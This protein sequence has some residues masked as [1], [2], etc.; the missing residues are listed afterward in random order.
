MYLFGFHVLGLGSDSQTGK[1]RTPALKKLFIF[2]LAPFCILS[3]LGSILTGSFFTG[4]FRN[5]A[6]HELIEK[7]NDF[8]KKS[9]STIRVASAVEVFSA[10]SR[11]ARAVLLNRNADD[12]AIVASLTALKNRLGAENA[13]ILDTKGYVVIA[14][15]DSNSNLES[16]IGKNYGSMLYYRE[17]M[18]GRSIIYPE[19]GPS[20]RGIYV[21][22]PIRERITGLTDSRIIGVATVKINPGYL[23]E[24]LAATF[25][26]PIA[27]VSPKGR[28]LASNLPEWL[29]KTSYRTEGFGENVGMQDYIEYRLDQPIVNYK[30]KRHDVIKTNHSNFIDIDGQW[31]VCLLE[32][33]PRLD[34]IKL[35][36]GVAGSIFLSL[37]LL[38][39]FM[40]W[41]EANQ[42]R[43]W[44]EKQI[45][46]A[47]ERAEEASRSKSDFLASMSHEIRTP[48]N[49]I[50][51]MSELALR[52]D[53]PPRVG[54]HVIAIKQA[55]NNLLAIINDI[56]D[57][58]KIESGK[59]DI[60][61]CEYEVSSLFSDVC[62]IIKT[63]MDETLLL[64]TFIDS[65]LPS[66]LYGD[67]TRIRQVILNIL[68][69][70]VKYTKKGHVS[71][72]IIGTKKDG[73]IELNI[74]VSDTGIGIKKEDMEKLFGKFTRFDSDKNRSIEGTGLGLSIA[75][76][77]C[78]MM[79]GNISVSSIYGEGSVFTITLPQE[80]RSEAEMASLK[81]PEKADTLVFEQRP[82]YLNSITGALANLG[83]PYK[84]VTILSDFYN[85]L[86]GGEY[87]NVIFPNYLY[88]KG[89]KDM[90]ASAKPDTELFL[91]LEYSET[92][93]MHNVRTL[94]MPI[95]CISIANAFNHQDP[96]DSAAMRGKLEYFTAPQAMVLVVDDISTN[97]TVMEG[98]LA[99]YK[100]QV[101]ICQSGEKAIEMVKMNKYDIIFMDQMMPGMDGIEATNIIRA[102]G[103][104]YEKLAILALTANAVKGVEEMLV[105]KGFSGY[106]S[107]PVE[108]PRLH[109]M[110]CTWVPAEKQIKASEFN[111]EAE[112]APFEIECIDVQAGITNTG[113]KVASYL[114]T[115]GLFCR[116]CQE[117]LDE[118]PRAL[119][120]NEL[121]KFITF[122]HALKSASAN[123]GASQ[124][125][126]K[127]KTLEE[128]GNKSDMEFI[129][130]H[131]GS[132]L[133]DLKKIVQDI[134][135]AISKEKA[136]PKVVEDISD[137]HKK[138]CLLKTALIEYDISAI[139]ELILALEKS[140]VPSLMEQISH[141]VLISDFDAAMGHIDGYLSQN[142]IHSNSK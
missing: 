116:D 89:I 58:S 141:D 84:S 129:E 110:L 55:G 111:T 10:T 119:E 4:H 88:D 35:N 52:E 70:A 6:T 86:N 90:L 85:E 134:L 99:P 32:P 115:L 27:F 66:R 5:E 44:A 94:P 107:K 30:G 68:N 67:Q 8:N 137:I 136:K 95:S 74:S 61:P 125:S 133:S 63:R 140:L 51:G 97:L 128:A 135:P 41:R 16:V 22:S 64:L 73:A 92:P 7:I 120:N 57:F 34:L 96:S 102:M 100:M 65:N 126:E 78:E 19:V 142:P 124:L 109:S 118:I 31:S 79:G 2:V 121:R 83:A 69:N 39:L 13:Y 71:L 98:L 77:L 122:V 9:Y 42:N 104:D 50:I 54:E 15:A 33:F 1:T 131:L 28:I 17:S 62:N 76:N 132:F 130:R 45:I 138:L 26:S 72:S 47:K 12:T 37:F 20:G 139:D 75:R 11:S 101:D 18:G 81:E 87:N 80:I 60:V 25:P 105:S 56:L 127:A 93:A 21:A 113:G 3:I 112:K 59:L 38:F 103:G 82:Q 117:K 46:L 114:K 40:S 48:M 123:V 108:T 53:L 24:Y 23:D 36:V 49:A 106:I 14:A 43:K 29:F 91:L